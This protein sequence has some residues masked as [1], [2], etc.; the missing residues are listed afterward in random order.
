[1]SR[2]YEQDVLFKLFVKRMNSLDAKICDLQTE[3]EEEVEVKD[4]IEINEELGN[5]LKIKEEL[6]VNDYDYKI[7]EQFDTTIGQRKWF[8]FF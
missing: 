3:L 5:K 7:V 4:D 8:Y 2:I 6:E 1:M